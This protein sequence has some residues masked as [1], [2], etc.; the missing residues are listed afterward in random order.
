MVTHCSRI[1]L[2]LS[3]W[4]NFVQANNY[5]LMFLLSCPRITDEKCKFLI[6][7]RKLAW[8]LDFP[9]GLSMST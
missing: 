2:D 1:F 5:I 8:F 4:I 7:A 6:I 3:N 9:T